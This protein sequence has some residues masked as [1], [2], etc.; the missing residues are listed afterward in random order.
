MQQLTLSDYKKLFICLS[1]YLTSLIAANTLG[2]KI[3]PFIWGTHL[4]VSIFYFPF[5]YLMTDV[6]GE[7]YGKTMARQF[8]LAGIVTTLLFLVF[9]IISVLMPW[10]A[11]GLWAHDAYNTIF[12]VSIRVS[13]A[14][15]AA[16]AIAE[17]QDVFA[18]FFF[19]KKLEKAGF[20]L[21]S[22]LATI[23]SELLDTIIFMVIAFYGVYSNHTLILMI[24]PWW[25]YKI[26]MGFVYTPLS[27]L[28]IKLLKKEYGN[29][30][31]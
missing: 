12:D 9:N 1:I 19:K 30:T 26:V 16:F 3:M 17:Y 7:V 14:S 29:T 2:L 31:N 5:V 22:L 23:W 15:V 18:Y 27:Y 20:W 11:A 13:I 25:I 21:W 24:I 10:S 8:V 6:V 28:G 4:S